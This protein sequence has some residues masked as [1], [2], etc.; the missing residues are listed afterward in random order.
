MDDSLKLKLSRLGVTKGAKKLKPAPPVRNKSSSAR[1]YPSDQEFEQMLPGA[2][3]Q[4]T[5][6]GRCLVFDKVYPLTFEQGTYPLGALLNYLPATVVPYLKDQRLQHLD[7]SQALFLDCETTGLAGAGTIAFMVGAAF[8]EQRRGQD[9]SE[10]YVFI[11]RQYFLRD[12]ADEQAMLTLLEQ[13]VASKKMLI[14]FNG[15]SFDIP[16]L[17]NR[18][19]LNRQPTPFSQ[20]PHFDLLLPARRLWRLRL[21]SCAL[22]SLETTLL[23][24][25]RSQQDVQGFLIPNMYHD[26]I[27]TGDPSELL[28][29][30]YHNHEDML[31]MVTLATE[32]MTLLQDTKGEPLDLLSLGKWQADLRLVAQAESC[33]TQVAQSNLP[34]E[35]YREALSRLGKLLKQHNRRSEAV[36]IWQQ[37][38]STTYD[39]VTAH[40][41]LAKYYEWHDIDYHQAIF[42]TKEGLILISSW[43]NRGYQ[44]LVKAELSHRLERLAQKQSR[45]DQTKR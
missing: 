13:L 28:R 22:G 21:G 36:P 30:F 2:S 37:I 18:Y 7:F 15:R 5:P 24:I 31:S 9:G 26:Y 8:F 25:K 33:L 16:L 45:K 10:S 11:V 41:E 42:W 23:N 14:T 20:M 43:R 3:V 29:V 4:E 38:A 35:H 34:L 27:R 12:H 1:S 44:Q 17:D 39:D 32:I 6:V 40:I 19:L